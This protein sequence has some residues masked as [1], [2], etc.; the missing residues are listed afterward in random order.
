MRRSRYS[1]GVPNSPVDRTTRPHWTIRLRA[2]AAFIAGSLWLLLW[3][4]QMVTHG[5]TQ[6]NEM[7]LALGLTWMDSGKLYVLPFLLLAVTMVGL[8]VGRLSP[9]WLGRGGFIGV[10]LALA[11]L[12]AGT[13]AQ[14]WGF[15]WGSYALTFEAAGSVIRAGGVLQALGSLL[16]TVAV[17][18]FGID[19]ARA[20]MLPVWTVPVLVLGAATTVF[21]TPSFVLPGLAWVLLGWALV[22][23]RPRQA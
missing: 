10:A 15:P 14:F 21:L 8:H 12:V 5:T 1:S 13:A 9:G 11:L 2:P 22:T 3:G 7:R 17:V 16:F 4:H 20:R 23:R 18:P 6:V 19:L